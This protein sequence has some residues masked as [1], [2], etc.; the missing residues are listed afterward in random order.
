MEMVELIDTQ[1]DVNRIAV[2]ISCVF[3]VELID[4]QWDVNYVK[5][6]RIDMQK[7]GINRY[8]VGCKFDK[9]T[10]VDRNN[11]R[12]NRYIVGC[13]LGLWNM[14]GRQYMEN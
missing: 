13:K 14:F 2:K 12:I 9:E 4:T 11:I 10:L 6:F 1:W 3:V 7:L 5:K 8:I